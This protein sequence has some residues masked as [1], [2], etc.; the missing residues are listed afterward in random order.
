MWDTIVSLI[1]IAL[2]VVVFYKLPDDDEDWLDPAASGDAPGSP[3]SKAAAAPADDA[4]KPTD[5]AAKPADDA[6]KPAGDAAAQPEQPAE[7]AEED[8]AEEQPE[9]PADDAEKPAS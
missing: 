4:A 5:D 9:E 2:V 8:G 3:E 6:A 1:A 7:D